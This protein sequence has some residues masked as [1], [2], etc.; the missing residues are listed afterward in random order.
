[1]GKD[2]VGGVT[3]SG[4][5]CVR[6]GFEEY[7]ARAAAAGHAAAGGFPLAPLTFRSDEGPPLYTDQFYDTERG[8]PCR[9]ARDEAGAYRCFPT[10]AAMH[11]TRWEGAFAD[12]SCSEKAFDDSL[13]Y[14][15]DR[16]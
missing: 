3:G 9:F 2:V 13:L 11:G 14:Y 7:A 4:L 5:R 1:M 10:E 15:T 12:A 8:E 16:A 6:L